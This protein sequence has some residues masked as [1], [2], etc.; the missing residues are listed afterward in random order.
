MKFTIEKITAGEDEVI[1]KY[2]QLNSEVENILSFFDR[3]QQKLVGKKDSSQ[4]VLD[5]HSILYIESV[6]GKTFAYT[7][8]DF[9]K[10]DYTLNQ[11]ESVLNEINFYRCSKSMIINI[12]RITTLQSLSS[13]RID[14]TM[15]NGEHIII[16]R[17][18]A[19][20]FRKILKGGKA[21]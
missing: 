8:S 19:S 12:D 14:A 13:N 1:L 3:K 6:D 10:L 7:E 11:L 5:K 16:S 17:T 20:Q 15:S 9:F 18:Y 4:M 21:R 2:R